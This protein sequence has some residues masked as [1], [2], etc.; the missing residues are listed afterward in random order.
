MAVFEEAHIYSNSIY[1][2]PVLLWHRFI[3]DIFC[4]WN[5]DINSLLTFVDYLNSIR[6][7]LQ[8]TCHHD[9]DK[10]SFLD[11]MVIR[12]EDNTLSTGLYIKPTDRN[13]LLQ[14]TSCH[15]CHVKNSLPK[16][17]YT[18]VKHIVSDPS[19][20]Q[21]RLA[22]MNTRF[23]RRGYPK[24][25][26]IEPMTHRLPTTINASPPTPKPCRLPFVHTYHP[27]M[28]KIHTVIRHHWPTL[29]KYYTSIPEFQN[30]RIPP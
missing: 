20:C 16:S 4:L 5:G 23:Q 7:E 27:I 9:P 1:Q 22:E 24:N 10:V 6:P 2:Q 25:F 14:Y 12:T 15:P 28:P 26:L 29:R 8:F 21:A 19:K 17:Q 3:D 30:P 11:T 18:R 13:N